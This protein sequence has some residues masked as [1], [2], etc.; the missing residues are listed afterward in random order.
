MRNPKITIVIA[1][2]NSEKTIGTALKSVAEQSLQDW[3]CIV[4]DGASK[5]RT[6]EIVK[7]FINDSRFC[8]ISEPDK[9]IY[10]AFNKGWKMAKGEWVYYLGSDD[11]LINSGLAN[12]LRDSSSYDI[13]G[14]GVLLIRDGY[15]AKVQLTRGIRGCHQ[16][17][18]VKRELF[19]LLNGFNQNYKLF[20]D[21]D[22]LIR[23]YNS[24]YKVLNRNII[25]A[26]FSLG[27]ASQSFKVLNRVFIERYKIYK[28]NNYTK[29]PL[30]YCIW[31]YLRSIMIYVKY[32]I[33]IP[34]YKNGN[35]I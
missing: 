24:G 35:S 5:D 12:L 19:P 16:A 23:A 6:I 18:I 22:F 21:T 1:T 15:P 26:G 27:G 30:L 17:F 25:V 14:G 9:G 31:R 33:R 11:Y 4:V 28:S 7:E 2:Y 3:E 32:K 10:D 20:A 34:I 13:I 29:F 8:Y